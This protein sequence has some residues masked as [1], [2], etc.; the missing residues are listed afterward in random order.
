MYIKLIWA[1]IFAIGFI[2]AGF[3]ERD[4][5]NN[6]KVEYGLYIAGVILGRICLL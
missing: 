4:H 6:K 2:C 3:Y 1:L 5:K